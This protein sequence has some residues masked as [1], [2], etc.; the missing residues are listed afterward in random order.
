[1]AEPV[2]TAA[3]D[4]AAAAAAAEMDAADAA[5]GGVPDEIYN[6]AADQASERT[7]GVFLFVFF[8]KLLSGLCCVV[9]DAWMPACCFDP[10]ALSV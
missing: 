1:M 2:T 7:R 8:F 10:F 9:L 6:W 5:V 4:A 3:A